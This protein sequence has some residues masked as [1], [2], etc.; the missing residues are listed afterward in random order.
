MATHLPTIFLALLALAGGTG[1]GYWFGL[2]QDAAQ[3]RNEQRQQSGELKSSW[4]VMPG[5]GKRVAGLLLALVAIQ[6]VCPIFFADGT[7]WW[8]SGGV[9]VGYGYQLFKHLQQQ[10]LALAAGSARGR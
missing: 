9:A 4:A 3:R 5:S 6:L 8:I 2:I 1:I 10:R 7:Q